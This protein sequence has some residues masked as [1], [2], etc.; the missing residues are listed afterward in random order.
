[1][2]VGVI[3]LGHGYRVLIKAFNLANFEISYAL[4]DIGDQSTALYSNI[5]SIKLVMKDLI[6][7]GIDIYRWQKL[8][9]HGH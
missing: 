8:P 5:F 1:M 2:K 3:G 9:E 6:I 7:D 4:T